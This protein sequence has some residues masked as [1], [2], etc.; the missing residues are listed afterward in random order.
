MTI[1]VFSKPGCGKCEA[2]KD[3]LKK[4]GLDFDEHELSYHIEPHEGWRE[5][6]SVAVMAAHT[7]MDTMPI[8]RVGEEFH[9]YPGAMRKL[10]QMRQENTAAAS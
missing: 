3:K 8:I 2:A 6:G 7:L 5:D 9:D 1:H 4:M 10:K